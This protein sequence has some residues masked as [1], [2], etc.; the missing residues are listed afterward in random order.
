M[1]R[2][3]ATGRSG[4]SRRRIRA[5]TT[6]VDALAV[7]ELSLGQHERLGADRQ[8]EP[9]VDG[10]RDDQVDR[11]VLVLE[12]HERDA[13]R[14]G[15]ALARDHEPRHLRPASPWRAAASSRLERTP[16]RQLGTHQLERV[17][18]D[19]DLRRAVVGDQ[20][21]PRRHLA[22]RGASAG[23]SGSASCTGPSS[24]ASSSG[25]RGRRHAELPERGAAADGR[26]AVDERVARARPREPLERLAAGAAA[27]GEVRERAERARRARAR[28]RPPS[29]RACAP[30]SRSR[31]PSAPRRPRR[32]TRRGCGRR[33]ARAR[34]CPAAAP[35]ARARPA[36]RSPSAA[37][38]GGRT[39]TPARSARAATPTGRRA[40]RTRPS[41]TSE[42]RS[43]R[44]RRSGRT[45]ARRPRARRR[46]PSRPR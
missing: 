22:Q 31:A 30:R 42:S 32:G 39:G 9:V 44:S 43:P 16:G 5:T 19:R 3:S 15:R 28:R 4:R 25:K 45:R 14:G 26:R 6:F 17:R 18:V 34:R 33:R 1:W 23:S 41:A 20:E 12:Q 36:G 38:S 29:R 37:R 7:F 21:L 40:A 35:R 8:A 46:S 24:R 2:T 11:P 10:R 13:L 27:R